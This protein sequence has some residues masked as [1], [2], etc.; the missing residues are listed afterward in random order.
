MMMLHKR[1]QI[2]RRKKNLINYYV[3]DDD[4]AGPRFTNEPFKSFFFL[5]RMPGETRTATLRTTTRKQ[6]KFPGSKLQPN[7]III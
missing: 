3:L 4:F 6:T 5:M 2:E 7:N 1:N